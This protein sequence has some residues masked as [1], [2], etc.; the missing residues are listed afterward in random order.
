MET[1]GGAVPGSPGRNAHAWFW[2]QPG[3]VRGGERSAPAPAP[4]DAAGP[5]RSCPRSASGQGAE[6]PTI[7]VG[8]PLRGVFGT[9]T[10][11]LGGQGPRRVTQRIGAEPGLSLTA[12]CLRRQCLCFTWPSQGH[13][14]PSSHLLPRFLVSCRGTKASWDP[15]DLL[16]QRV[17]RWVFGRGKQLLPSIQAGRSKPLGH[18]G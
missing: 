1:G 16:D 5:L 10:T 15:S 12:Q 13:A 4:E 7:Q 17:K 2:P 3:E 14:P 18:C 9:H 6:S 8:P 11:G